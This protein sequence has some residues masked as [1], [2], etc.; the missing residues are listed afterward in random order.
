MTAA[1][2]YNPRNRSAKL[3]MDYIQ[4]LGVFTITPMPTVRSRRRAHSRRVDAEL[5]ND[6][7]G[8]LQEVKNYHEGKV[9]MK[10][11]EE[12]FYEL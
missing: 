5:W 3:A 11:A 1:V 8:A 9:Q 4:S 10:S 6:L 2:T 12:L 7:K